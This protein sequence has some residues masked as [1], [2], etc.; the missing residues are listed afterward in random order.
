MNRLQLMKLHSLIAAFMLPVAIMFMLTGGLYTWD[1]KGSFSNE[2]YE[3]NL[4]KPLIGD[5]QSLRDI[6]TK[7]LNRLGIDKPEGGSK[8]KGDGSHF[9]L[10]WA[11]SS[12]VVILAP[13]DNSNIAKLTV[14]KASLYKT[15][16]QLHKAK[17]GVAFKVYATLFSIAIGVLLVSGFI[18][19]LQTPKLKQVTLTTALAGILTFILLVWLS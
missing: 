4:E 9:Y 12:K 16:A 7:E 13:T 18:M 10:E 5:L 6:T 8:I 17:G 2:V 15:F 3:V 11:G 14:K 1:M 19:A